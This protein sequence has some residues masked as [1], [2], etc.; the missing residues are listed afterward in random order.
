MQFYRE[1][2]HAE[3]A[4]YEKASKINHASLCT[5]VVFRLCSSYK[6]PNSFILWVRNYFPAGTSFIDLLQ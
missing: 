6:R 5:S 3:P 1:I 2:S 4:L